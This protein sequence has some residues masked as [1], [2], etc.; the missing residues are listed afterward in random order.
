MEEVIKQEE[1]TKI[2][3]R[4]WFLTTWLI[5]MILG[6]ISGALTYILMPQAYSYLPGWIIPVNIAVSL[7]NLGSIIA[8]FLWKKWGFWLLCG[9]CI[10]V[11]VLNLSIGVGIGPSILGLIGVPILFGVLQIGKEKKGWTQLT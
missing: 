9:T 3:S 8:L 4:H 7:I 11:F 6:N 5:L 2:K 10:S 1:L